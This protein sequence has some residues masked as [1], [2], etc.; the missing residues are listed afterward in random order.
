MRE[1]KCRVLIVLGAVFLCMVQFDMGDH[2]Y[3]GRSLR[4]FH[5]GPDR[6]PVHL[7]AGKRTSSLWLIGLG[8]AGTGCLRYDGYVPFFLT[9]GVLLAYMFRHPQERRR[10]AIPVAGALLFWLFAF[11]ALPCLMKAGRGA[12]GT[13]YAKMA[14]VVCDIVAEGGKVSPEDMELIEQEIMPREVIMRQYGLY[15]D[16]H[17]SCRISRTW[18]KVSSYGPV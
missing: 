15:K 11:A 17:A 5:D 6:R 10:L 12:S 7:H 8:L 13:R 9:T 18:G 4:H 16:S 1:R 2:H 14:H 3:Q